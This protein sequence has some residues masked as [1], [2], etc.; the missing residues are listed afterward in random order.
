MPAFLAHLEQGLEGSQRRV[1]DVHMGAHMLD[2]VGGQGLEGF[3]GAVAGVVEGQGGLA[4]APALDALEQRAAH[5]PTRLA[6]RQRGIEVDMGLD[7][8]RH[9]QV[10]GGVQVVGAEGRC[11]GLAGDAG[12]QA[13]FQ[14]QYVQAVVVAQAGVDYEHA[15]DS[16]VK[17]EKPCMKCICV[18]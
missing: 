9:H 17:G 2:A 1:G 11:F 5:V 8:G 13:F 16:R 15:G 18:R 10:A 7:K 3:V 14:V 6:R 4:L 12:D